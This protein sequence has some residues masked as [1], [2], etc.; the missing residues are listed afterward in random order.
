MVWSLYDMNPFTGGCHYDLGCG[1]YQTGCG[2]CPQLGSTDDADL[3]AEIFQRK[4]E[5]FS[6]LEPER[7]HLVPQNPWMADQLK[8]SPLLRKFPATLI[9]SGVDTVQFAPHDKQCARYFLGLPQEAR[10]ILFVSDNL[11]N[12]RKG[13]SALEEA[14]AGLEDVTNLLLLCVGHGMT[15]TEGI[16][17]KG[18]IPYINLGS[19]DNDHKLGIV[20]NTADVFVIPSLQDNMPN[21]VLEALACG[22]P[23]VGFRVGGIPEMVRSGINGLLVPEGDVVALRAAIIELLENPE[24]TDKMATNCRRIAVE[25]YSLEVMAKNYMELYRGILAE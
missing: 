17:S 11:K 25:E 24:K 15:P 19:I 2:S 9:P 6:R 22:I 13:I 12:M 5:T 14:L 18:G 16:S 7:L 4:L 3:S 10:I 21:T 23:V 1:K 20:Y 8:A